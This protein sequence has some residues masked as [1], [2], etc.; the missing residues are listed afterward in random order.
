MKVLIFVQPK[1]SMFF[2]R[3]H[4]VWYDVARLLLMA[5]TDFWQNS[6]PFLDAVAFCM[7]KMVTHLTIKV[8]HYS[9]SSECVTSFMKGFI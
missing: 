5:P 6:T 7:R 8:V 3:H 2:L 9:C 1:S 4:T